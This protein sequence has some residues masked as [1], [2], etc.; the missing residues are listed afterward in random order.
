[1]GRSVAVLG[2]QPPAGSAA[3]AW[4]AGCDLLVQPVAACPLPAAG[5]PDA[6]GGPDQFRGAAQAGAVASSAAA[7][8]L[9]L[10]G[11][12]GGSGAPCQS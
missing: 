3:P 11:A 4:L 5:S 2:Q 8:H 9:V 12:R 6:G 10:T 7:K 1:M